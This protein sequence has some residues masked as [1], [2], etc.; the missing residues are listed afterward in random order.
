MEV[1]TKE[2]IRYI[3]LR[4]KENDLDDLLTEV[5]KLNNFFETNQYRTNKE[6]YEQM[7]KLKE[8]HDI[9]YSALHEIKS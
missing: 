2:I 3:D 5:E 6:F 7:K 1:K 8:F 4:F 9:L